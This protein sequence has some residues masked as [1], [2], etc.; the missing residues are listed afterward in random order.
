MSLTPKVFDVLV[1]LVNN[2]GRLV[3]RE[4][5]MRVVWADSYVEESNLTVSISALRKVLAEQTDGRHYIET[6]PKRGYRF[7]ADVRAV[8][9]EQEELIVREQTR[10]QVIIEQTEE[11]N[12]QSGIKAEIEPYAKEQAKVQA[13]RRMKPQALIAWATMIVMMTGVAYLWKAIRAKR[14]GVDAQIRSIA[15]LPFKHLGEG[16][17]DELLGFGMA[18]V[19]ITRTGSLNQVAVRPT[20]AVFKYLGAEPDI[21]SVGKELKVDAVLE[22]GVQR[23]G[24]RIRV[25]ARLVRA[26]DGDL[27]WAETFDG[28]F[29]DLFA[30]QDEMSE[31]VAIALSVNVGEQKKL[32]T[33]RYTK[34]GEAY[35]VYMR[36]RY[37][38]NKRTADDLKKAIECFK[39]AIEKDPSYALAFAGLADSY[40]LLGDY[41][42][43]PAREVFP[44]MKA[45]AARAVEM[46]DQLAETHTSLAYAKRLSDWD[47]PGAEEEFA[48]AIDLNYSYATAHHWYSEYLAGMGRF[49]EAVEEARRAV[50][51]DPQSLIINTNVGWIYYLAHS[52][53]KAIEELKKTLEMDPSFFLAKALLWQAYA[54]N[55]MYEE[56]L[57]MGAE[58]KSPEAQ[59]R[60]EILRKAYEE[61]G[62][63]GFEL[64]VLEWN[65]DGQKGNDVLA[66]SIAGGYT[67]AGDYDSAF[68]WLQKAYEN[69]DSQM[70]W[71]KVNPDFDDL[72]GDPRFKD[73]L[74][75]MRLEP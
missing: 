65:L 22:G 70:V 17:K 11:T 6:V 61:G 66:C 29:K 4:E 73:L 30:L 62:W 69:R 39:Q 43:A 57:A 53:D 9:A 50:E 44:K 55:G 20:S 47:W 67:I 59:E 19:L 5:L 37:F 34:S 41:N 13:S 54:Q 25:T 16:E 18:D 63:K 52:Y 40:A 1:M 60:D 7:V 64:K 45:A 46:D 14:V 75:R 48:R 23:I 31:Q 24:E 26:R 12:D 2:S 38:W 28:R 49:D 21:V 71:L 35:Q 8:G 72:H 33:K 51:L 56:A 32:L 58:S 15:V 36:G 74:R 27:L 42:V 68:K 10:A 3:E